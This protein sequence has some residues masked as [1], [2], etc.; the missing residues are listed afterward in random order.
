VNGGQICGLRNISSSQ[1]LKISIIAF[2]NIYFKCLIS[3]EM[4]AAQ[5]Y[6]GSHPSI[7][8]RL[9][10]VAVLDKMRS[11]FARTIESH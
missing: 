6:E 5:F 1:P 2:I 3:N 7:H 11:K 9:K 10:D 8:L 4:I